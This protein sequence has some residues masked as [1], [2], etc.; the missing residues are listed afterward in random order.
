MEQAAQA[1][2]EKIK[3]GEDMGVP[4]PPTIVPKRRYDTGPQPIPQR[5]LA[6]SVE[7]SEVEKESPALLPTKPAPL[8]PPQFAQ[9]S[10]RFGTILQPEPVGKASVSQ[11]VAQAPSTPAVRSTTQTLQQRSSQILQ[12]P[13]AGFF[14]NDH[15]RPI[16]QPQPQQQ[17]ASAPAPHQQQQQPRQ[18]T[19]QDLRQPRQ[20]VEQPTTQDGQE[21]IQ[22]QHRP[23]HQESQQMPSR[24][25]QSLQSQQSA[26]SMAQVMQARQPSQGSQ[27]RIAPSQAMDVD[28]RPR[29]ASQQQLQSQ[30]M[31]RSDPHHPENSSGMRR[32]DS[33]GAARQTPLQSLAQSRV[34]QT[35]SPPQEALRPS[36]V[37]AA[38]TQQPP[39]KSNIMNLLNDEPAEPQSRKR[40]SDARPAAPTPPPQSPAGQMYQQTIQP[41]QQF[42]RRELANETSHVVQ[43][44]HMQR[45][46]LGQILSQQ[47]GPGQHRDALPTNWAEVAQRNFNERQQPNYQKQLAESPRMQPSFTQASR[48]PLQPLQRTH[49][50][51]PPPIFAHS[52]ASSYASLHS[53]QQPPQTIQQTQQPSQSSAQATPVLQ[54][55]PYAQIHPHIQPHQQHPHSH[56]SQQQQYPAQ[57]LHVLQQ[58]QQQH[59]DPEPMTAHQQQFI[60][61]QEAMQQQRRQDPFRQVQPDQ[62]RQQEMQQYQSILRPQR[63]LREANAVMEGIGRRED[64]AKETARREE[65]LRRE[66]AMRREDMAA[67]RT[68]HTPPG[69]SHNGGFQQPR[70]RQPR[71][72]DERERR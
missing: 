33:H 7:T 42:S 16:L 67:R 23:R 64:A 18:H 55:S 51:T 37:P 27:V 26:L 53:Q 25:Q 21:V 12:G 39:K 72:Y 58:Q 61:Q 45:P 59:R 30:Q 36:S 46:S 65:I 11:P 48:P 1:A 71:G 38:A 15:A 22:T 20:F 4:P 62:S 47:P 43:Q 6:P 54:P 13:R 29:V 5:Q 52:R 14:S 24:Y 63:D 70:D 9:S 10:Q 35:F 3:R 56:S 32:L 40:I 28:I 17:P 57:H 31:P 19:Q 68:N 34:P 50:P 49:A 41:T 66:E 69:Y 2:D 44:Q 8:S 60:R